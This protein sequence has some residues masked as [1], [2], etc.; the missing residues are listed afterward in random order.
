[1]YGDKDLLAVQAI[2]MLSVDA[3]EKA[4]SGHPGL[5]MGAAPM[6]Y[7]LWSRFMQFNPSKPDWWNRD[8]FVL[9]AG[10]GSMLQYSLLHL[11]GFDV[12]MDDLKQ[13]RQWGSAAPGHPEYGHTPGVECTTGPLGQG[14]AMAVGMAMAERFLAARYNR[15]G[16]NIMDHYTYCL[17]GDGDLMEGVAAEA[18]SLA[19]HLRLGK[20]IVLYDSNDISLDGET[21]H[22]FTERTADRFA[23]YGWQVLRVEDGNDLYAIH[24]AIEQAR[25]SDKPTLVEVKTI[26]GYGSPNKAGTSDCHGAPLAAAEVDLVRKAYNWPHPPFEIPED[27]Y[28]TCRLAARRGVEAEQAWNETWSAYRQ[29]HPELA[30]ELERAFAGELPVG[31]ESALP[32]YAVGEKVATRDASGKAINAL[33]SAIPYFL[34]GSA[35]LASSNKTMIRG[36]DAYQP[37]SYHG[38]NIWFG[39]REH[40]MAAAL[41]GMSL[42]G[43]V[44]VY[45]GTF[46]VFSDY[47]KPAMRLSALMK[48]PVIYVLTHDS[49]AVGEDG[50]THQPIE[51]LPGLRSIPNLLVLRPS[52]ANE[53]SAAYRIALSQRSRPSAIVLTRQA[54]PVKE[55]TEMGI[56]QASRGAYVRHRAA[57]GDPDLLLIASGSEVPLAIDAAAALKEQGIKA[58]VVSM[59]SWE[60]F[61]EQD[62]EYRDSV[63]PPHIRKRVCIEMGSP[64]GW[65]RYA[66]SDGLIIALDHFGASAPGNVLMEKYGFTK[67]QVVNRIRE[68]YIG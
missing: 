53:T 20:L 11:F 59:I 16:F 45:G 42:H 41:N 24:D 44:K 55:G 66:G 37:G 30:A 19:G 47:M 38:R 1:M 65:E 61:E 57:D 27:V 3:I 54:L 50:P 63:I 26:I 6:A 33:A 56:G 18:A 28:E 15:E 67:D 7:V 4:G 9:S 46:F 17:C 48:Q 21:K 68:W 12:S 31:W 34:G 14:L 23:A 52:D 49:I 39:V 10:H 22:A 43:G 35:D 40:A 51:Q 64:L 8:R 32:V 36:E 25:Q 2:R 29:A 5:P 60:L 13:F 58:N 62:R